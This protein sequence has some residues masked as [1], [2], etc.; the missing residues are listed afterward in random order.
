VTLPDHAAA[1]VKPYSDRVAHLVDRGEDV[2]VAQR[3]VVGPESPPLELV[4]SREGVV[5]MVGN[6]G[7][8]GVASGL[9]VTVVDFFGLTEPLSAH[10]APPT[11]GRPGHEKQVP[12]AY[13]VAMYGNGDDTAFP[14][15]EMGV[16][17]P[18]SPVVAGQVEAARDVLQCGE[19]AELLAATDGELTWGRFWDNLTGSVERTNL[20]IP[21]DAEE[22]RDQ[23]C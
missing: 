22:A 2:V 10:M 3:W 21:H 8:Y 1:V 9:D 7:V 4:P 19:V 23:Y 14:T 13:F 11:P 16:M 20:R 12:L 17:P 18:Y 15:S 6:A 5:F